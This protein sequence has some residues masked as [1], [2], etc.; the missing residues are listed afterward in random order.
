MMSP[1]ILKIAIL[2]S[3]LLLTFTFS[4]LPL[5]VRMCSNRALTTRRR[6]FCRATV[7]LLSCFAAGVFI[8]ICLL[9][10]FPEVEDTIALAL[11]AAEIT[12]SFP[13]PEFI[14]VLGFLILLIV[15]QF[16]LTWKTDEY[17]ERLEPRLLDN[18]SLQSSYSSVLNSGP[19]VPPMGVVAEVAPS[20][21]AST[22]GLISNASLEVE[23]DL[24]EE[25]VNAEQVYTDPSSH[26]VIRSMILLIALSIHSL[27]EGL[28][29]G[30]QETVDETFRLFFALLLHKCVV[31]F[32][33]GLNMSQSKLSIRAVVVSNALFS[34]ASPVGIALGIGIV[35]ETA[36]LTE[37]AIIGTLN[38][39]AC[40]TFI[41]I[42]FFE[43]RP[44][45]FMRKRRQLYPDRM[46]KVFALIIGFS[47]VVGV[48]FLD[49][50]V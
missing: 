50:A 38:G 29:V 46:M 36:G 32:S 14:V 11:N 24:L 34:V 21:F 18:D 20:T 27:L 4:M 10:L 1:E 13:L 45:E 2:F 30:L 37:H 17:A 31:A 7:S 42:V 12:T 5:I 26:S 19:A 8:G 3:L 28:A 40:G 48:I 9:D 6:R 22:D 23:N 35:H 41:Y 44:H 25:D 33:V 49:P 15:E 47:V 16:V 39:L 43:I